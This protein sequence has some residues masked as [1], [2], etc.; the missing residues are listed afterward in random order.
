VSD[1]ID[2]SKCPVCGCEHI[3]GGFVEICGLEAVQA[4]SCTVC[5]TSWEEV[6]SFSNRQNIKMEQETAYEH[7]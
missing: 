6:Y 7:E 5:G 4:V 2:N 3:E 1:G